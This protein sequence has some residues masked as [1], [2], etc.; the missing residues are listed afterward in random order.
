MAHTNALN[1]PILQFCS[2]HVL[3]KI[4]A[5]RILLH[6]TLTEDFLG[7]QLCTSD[8]P[9]LLPSFNQLINFFV[10]SS[11]TTIFTSV[12]VSGGSGECVRSEVREVSCTQLLLEVGCLRGATLSDAI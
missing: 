8:L 11:L 10:N 6:G 7:K 12:L 4:H 5:G 2:L 3:A 1:K 9:Y